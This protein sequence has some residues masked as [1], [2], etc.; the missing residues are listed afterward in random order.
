MVVALASTVVVGA[1]PAGAADA[2]TVDVAAVDGGHLRLLV[3]GTVV[4]VGTEHLGDSRTAEPAAIAA[5]RTG[6]GYLVAG[7][8]GS[9]EAFGDARHHGDL[10]SFRLARDVIAMAVT[11]S[12][13][14]YWLVG[15]DGGV[16]SFGDA[17]FHGSMGG[18][19][20]AQPVVGIA[21]SP[22][23]GGYWLV[24]ADGGVFAFGDAAFKGSMGSQRLDRPVIGVAPSMTGDGYFMVG[25]DGGVFSFG[26]AEFLGSIGGTGRDDVVAISPTPSGVGYVLATVDGDVVGFG[27]GVGD[28]TTGSIDP[29]AADLVDRLN[30]ERATRGIG[31]LRVDPDLMALAQ[32]WSQHMAAG[33][34]LAHSDLDA[35]LRRLDGMGSV[36]LALAEN[37]YWGNGSLASPAAAHEWF[38]GSR[39]HRTN[40]LA[41]TYTTVGIGIACVDG[42]IW[43]TELFA[44]PVAD[45]RASSP[46]T[47]PSQPRADFGA[48]PAPSC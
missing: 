13:G 37:I 17:Q 3:D 15:A 42:A 12:G 31:A 10:S 7:A 29:L 46:S 8:N 27:D 22:T 44:R 16:F 47:A 32:E 4:A 33:G 5:T 28:A 48:W 30:A 11:P 1:A 23:G 35:Q 25:S 24:A 6:N 39:G 26:D 9:I 18:I 20:L 21:S 36:N 38:M 40:M 2:R 41:S 45:G 34:G 19:R 14:G 43:V